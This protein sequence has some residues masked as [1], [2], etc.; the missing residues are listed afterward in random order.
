MSC[1]PREVKE[2]SAEGNESVSK[3]EEASDVHP[4]ETSARSS[5][6][7]VCILETLDSLVEDYDEEEDKDYQLDSEESED[8]GESSE[9]EDSYDDV[10]PEE[11]NEVAK[12]AV[13]RLDPVE[14][15]KLFVP[16]V[17]VLRDGK[18]FASLR[19]NDAVE[20]LAEKFKLIFS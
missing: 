7:E 10:D 8:E 11:L 1:D 20:E 17:T 3:A 2:L 15:S 13:D 4:G 5:E 12:S 14:K 16:G 18:S 9:D 19:N 6:V